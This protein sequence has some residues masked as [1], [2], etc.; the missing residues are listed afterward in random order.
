MSSIIGIDEKTTA[1]HWAII[2]RKCGN[3]SGMAIA[4][5]AAVTPRTA[6]ALVLLLCATGCRFPGVDTQ[7]PDYHPVKP[8]TVTNAASLFP[9][10]PTNAPSLKR[11]TAAVLFTPISHT[12]DLP[13][14]IYPENASDFR[15]WNTEMSTDGGRTW[16]TFGPD[17]RYA[18]AEERTNWVVVRATNEL[19][20]F[21][22]R[23]WNIPVE[24][25]VLEAEAMGTNWVP[26][27]PGE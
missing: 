13:K 27:N 15:N 26:K 3:L 4:A 21:R 5:W 7:N 25:W 9:P 18:P 6:W 20:L 11:L 16:Q 14:I 17:Y 8:P 24:P 10:V 22:M 1:Y 12:N 2:Q 23:G 19:T